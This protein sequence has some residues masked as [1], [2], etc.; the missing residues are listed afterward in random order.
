METERTES[1]WKRRP[2]ATCHAPLTTGRMD[3]LPGALLAGIPIVE[4]AGSV[5]RCSEGPVVTLCKLSKLEGGDVEAGNERLGGSAGTVGLG[6]PTNDTRRF[7]GE[8]GS[9]RLDARAAVGVGV[10]PGAGAA[11]TGVGC[12]PDIGAALPGSGVRASG[13][14]QDGSP[15][16]APMVVAA[17]GADAEDAA[18]AT[19]PRPIGVAVDS[20]V[21]GVGRAIEAAGTVAFP[22]RSSVVTAD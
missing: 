13:A 19:G 17:V 1:D 18:C 15:L 10:P 8:V 21:A 12:P 11:A 6:S 22:N 4:R 3:A 7:F 5:F 2:C 20:P 16:G 14:V 9:R